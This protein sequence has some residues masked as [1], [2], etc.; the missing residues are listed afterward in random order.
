[1]GGC[2][3]LHAEDVA[4]VAARRVGDEVRYAFSAVCGKFLEE[5]FRLWFCEGPH[6]V[7]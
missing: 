7:V 3:Y 1:V 5:D 2:L 6:I 4:V